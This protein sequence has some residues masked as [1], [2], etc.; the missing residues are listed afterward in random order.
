MRETLQRANCLAIKSGIEKGKAK[1][2]V[3]EIVVDMGQYTPWCQPFWCY[4]VD[5]IFICVL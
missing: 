3:T 1:G 4:E 2:Q 5:P